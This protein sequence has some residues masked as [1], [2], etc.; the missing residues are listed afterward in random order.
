MSPPPALLNPLLDALFNNAEPKSP[1]KAFIADLAAHHNDYTILVPPAHV[2]QNAADFTGQP[3][4]HL[5]YTSDDFVRSHVVRSA[6]AHASS[7]SPSPK[8]QLYIVS[9]A[10]GRQLL[11]KNDAV[12][13]GKGFKTSVKLRALSLGC[14]VPFLDLFP[15]GCTFAVIYIDSSLYGP[16]PG[17]ATVLATPS[18][19]LTA[20]AHV[21]KRNDPPISF[22]ELLRNFP[23]LSK[24]MALRFYLLFHHNNRQFQVLR[25][26]KKYPL[27]TVKEMFDLLV[28]EAFKIVQTCVNSDSSDGDRAYNLLTSISNKFPGLDLLRLI[29]EYVELNMYDKIWLQL[30][31]QYEDAEP[32]EPVS[33]LDGPKTLLT[34]RLYSDLSCLSLNQLDIPV[35]EPWL[36]N[37]LYR[38]ISEAIAVFSTLNDPAVGNQRLKTA[39]LKQTVEILTGQ[40]ESNTQS[41][42]LI[43][44]DT[45]IGLLIMVVVHSK[46]QHLECHLYYIRQFGL[47][48]F[49]LDNKSTPNGAGYL[50]YI[51]SNLEAVI[52]HLHGHGIGPDEVANMAH[53]SSQNYDFWYTLQQE[54]LPHLQHLLDEARATFGTKELPRSHFLKSKNIHGESGLFFAVKSGNSEVLKLL[55]SQTENWIL[56][57]DILFDVNTT[58]N[59]NL[60]MLALQ[61]E[62]PSIIMELLDVI[63]FSATE[64]EQRAYFN[65][66]NTSG[67]TVGHYLSHNL[68]ALDRI[69]HLIDWEI[70]DLNSHTPLFTLCRC[71]D[72][73]DYLTL[74]QKVFQFVYQLQSRTP[75]SLDIHADKSGN[76][77][78]HA[79]ARGLP[80]SQLLTKTLLLIDVNEL[81][82]KGLSPL[83]LYIRYNRLENLQYLLQD[84]RLQFDQEEPRYYYTALDYYSISATKSSGSHNFEG[85]ERLILGHHFR[86][87]YASKSGFKVAFVGAKYE[88]S[89]SDWQINTVIQS[90]KKKSVNTIDSGNHSLENKSDHEGYSARYVSLDKI[91]QF[92]SVQNI[93][94]PMSFFP[95][96]SSFWINFPREKSVLPV[97]VKHQSNR[98]LDHLTFCFLTI[99]F[100]RPASR[101][102][103]L[104]L[105]SRCCKDDSLMLELTRELSLQSDAEKSRLKDFR[106]SEQK[107]QEVSFFIEYSQADLQKYLQTLSRLRKALAI[108]EMKSS[109][110][111]IVSIRFTRE[112][113]GKSYESE[114][115]LATYNELLRY[116]TWLEMCTDKLTN[117]CSHILAN[118]QQWRTTYAKIKD[119]NT[120]L[121]KFEDLVIH[122]QEPVRR[123]TYS[124]E[125]A[126]PETEDHDNSYFSFGLVDSK[127]T[128]YKKL[129]M[130]KLEEVKRLIDLNA[131]IKLEHEAIAA[132]I[133]Q[134][135][136]YRSGVLELGIRRLVTQT[137]LQ[138]R[139][140]LLGLQKLVV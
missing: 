45:L 123:S 87:H 82:L 133:S 105:F 109:D 102:A 127:R 97:A 62:N 61:G 25:T 107:V 73:H 49:S 10:N 122:A 37:I 8:H 60:L 89:S 78:L 5:C 66:Q 117:N 131:E 7:S 79:L 28:A 96:E 110:V 71:Y 15:K 22:E 100:L 94:R 57:D 80:E 75:F 116:V 92:Y 44:A 95:A 14:F 54:N 86:S 64:E 111:T 67:R 48:S 24:S 58:T 108:A 138:T 40:D 32:G 21:D 85:V 103:L 36:L 126:L 139:K 130:A 68:D 69:G 106:L 118:V 104:R 124:S 121:H 128:R 56:L 119:L 132:E 113:V 33:D 39:V 137:L 42:P 38:R 34:L 74:I 41:G 76:T 6:S 88:K 101:S 9:S 18:V 65:S 120:E 13:T 11:L 98:N 27:L 129:V 19:P 70:K 23:L 115:D 35:D 4:K 81:N 55:L 31:F 17:P 136:E 63:L 99:E 20:S 114:P 93:A 59:Q 90:T 50:S 77:L 134:F 3:L 125:P 53:A 72:H 52:F 112:L 140:R 43:D 30:V 84:K 51:L 91:R 12:F 29:H 1:H 2:L 26:R 16:R 47:A 46:V 135:F 83:A